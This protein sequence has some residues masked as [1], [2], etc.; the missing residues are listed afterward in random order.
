MVFM[1]NENV[2]PCSKNGEKETTH[3][4]NLYDINPY[5]ISYLWNGLTKKRVEIEK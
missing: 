2:L 5:N 1:G 3:I 4:I